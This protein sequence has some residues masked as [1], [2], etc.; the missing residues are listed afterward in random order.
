MGLTDHT[1]DFVRNSLKELSQLLP[2]LQNNQEH[3]F[4]KGA[5]GYSPL[6]L[7]QWSAAFI[8]HKNDIGNLGFP[9]LQNRLAGIKF[10]ALESQI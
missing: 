7:F 2:P 9:V 10:P 5:G 4:V 6:N 3:E 8:E 1:I